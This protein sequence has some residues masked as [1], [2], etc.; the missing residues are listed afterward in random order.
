[1]NSKNLCVF[2]GEKFV[3]SAKSLV[4]FSAVPHKIVRKNILC[5]FSFKIVFWCF[6]NVFTKF[7][8]KSFLWQQFS[9]KHQWTNQVKMKMNVLLCNCH[10]MMCFSQKLQNWDSFIL[11][12]LIIV[13]RGGFLEI[14]ACNRWKTMRFREA[15]FSLPGSVNWCI[16]ITFLKLV[17]LQKFLC[18]MWL[19]KKLNSCGMKKVFHRKIVQSCLL[20]SI[21]LWLFQLKLEPLIQI[22][23]L[24]YKFRGTF[25]WS[26]G[27][28]G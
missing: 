1:M 8:L 2:T 18:H 15:V 23:K 20:V 27:N 4:A 14:K 19:K 13:L 9:F 6:I 5:L 28:K 25:F 17:S 24:C 3:L 21:C 26:L 10:V 12:P 16:S 22:A 7:V 11:I